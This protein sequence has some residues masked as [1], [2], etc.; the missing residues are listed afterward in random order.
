MVVDGIVGDK[1]R[2]ALNTNPTKRIQE[3]LNM[4]GW[5]L[6]ED[7]I[8]GHKTEHAVIEFQTK[9]KLVVD[10]VVGC[11]TKAALITE[12]TRAIQT[13]LVA[14]GAKLVVDGIQGPETH[15]AI[16]DFQ[17]ANGLLVDGWMGP[18]TRAVLNK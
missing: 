13:K 4:C 3:R 15:K 10:G 11:Q 12:D 2:L 17:K 18:K 16:E 6:V 8:F 14:K 7:G 5:Q 9:M 1:T